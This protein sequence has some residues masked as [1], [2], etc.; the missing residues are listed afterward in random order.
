MDVARSA[1]Q[2]TLFYV[3]IL[4]VPTLQKVRASTTQFQTKILLQRITLKARYNLLASSPN[5]QK[6]PT[7]RSQQLCCDEI[8]V[9]DVILTPETTDG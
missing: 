6:G 5:W 4:F 1:R 8:M 9:D 7:Y 2:R 3:D